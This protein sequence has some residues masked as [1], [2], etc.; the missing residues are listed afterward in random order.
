MQNMNTFERVKGRGR[1]KGGNE[2]EQ[3]ESGYVGR[4]TMEDPT[5][6]VHQEKYF[7][8]PASFLLSSF[9]LSAAGGQAGAA[10]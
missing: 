1:D 10:N 2:A 3:M 5:G 9:L 7:L 6:E 8:S 4:N